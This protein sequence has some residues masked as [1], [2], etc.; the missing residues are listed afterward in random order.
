VKLLLDTHIALWAVT[1]P[2]RLD[3]KVQGWISN[4]DND[5]AVSIISLWEIA[6][7]RSV[8]RDRANIPQLSPGAARIAFANADFD[9][10]AIAIGHIET[11]E[12]LPFHHRDP[13]DRML[14]A[15]AVADGCSLLTHDKALAVYGN[16]VMVV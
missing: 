8:R 6:I 13:F 15:T 4:P 7:K 16:F 5:V 9:L 1:T 2:E 10:L 3:E 14:V 12:K 11:V